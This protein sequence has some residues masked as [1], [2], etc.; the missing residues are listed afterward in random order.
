MRFRSNDRFIFRSAQRFNEAADEFS[1][2]LGLNAADKEA[3]QLLEQISSSQA[4]SIRQQQEDGNECEARLEDDIE[5]SARPGNSVG[6]SARI[7]AVV[8]VDMD[9]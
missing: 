3:A 9:D 5:A 2:A 4:G 7:W 1:A 6:E 8:D